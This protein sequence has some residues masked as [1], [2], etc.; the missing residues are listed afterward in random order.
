MCSRKITHVIFDLDGLLLGEYSR[1]PTIPFY[2]V[3]L[4]YA[5]TRKSCTPDAHRAFSIGT[6]S[7]LRGT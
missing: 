1:V 3:L 4:R 5:Q 7:S 6:A 2:L